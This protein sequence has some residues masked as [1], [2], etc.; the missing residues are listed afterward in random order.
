MSISILSI[1]LGIISIIVFVWAINGMGSK[2]DKS[3]KTAKSKKKD[4]DSSIV[5]IIVS[6]VLF[7]VA[8]GIYD[9]E[10]STGGMFSSDNAAQ[11][12]SAQPSSE[13]SKSQAQREVEE[14]N[15]AAVEKAAQ[16]A[17]KN[18]E[19]PTSAANNSTSN[20]NTAN[21]STSTSKPVKVDDANL[22][23]QREAYQNWYNQIEAKL[24]AVDTAWSALWPDNSPDAIAKLTKTLEME[25]S[26]LASITVPNELS[27]LHRQKL[28]DAARR[29]NEWI[30][31]RLKACQMK[32]A[33]AGQQDL[34]NEMAR[35]DGLKL[36]SNVEIK[37]IGRELGIN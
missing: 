20:D 8:L 37:N 1:P 35:G 34:L 21:D 19:Q 11:E 17:N 30:D 7:F 29:Y 10:G 4:N 13:S 6:L 23:K 32:S 12:Q 18:N 31:S 28:N 3:S 24:N 14:A 16:N 36:Q 9:S 26:Q 2:P 15:R 33:G 25:K 22:E 27:A 5:G